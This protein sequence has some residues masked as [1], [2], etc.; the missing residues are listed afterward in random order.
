MKKNTEVDEF[1]R[2]SNAIEGVFDE[3]SLQ[4]AKYAWEYLIKQETLTT[5]VILKTH[6]I[7]MLHQSLRPNEKGYWRCCQV[8][9]GGREAPRWERILLM[10]GGWLLATKYSRDEESIKED[11]VQFEFIHPFVD[12]NGRVGRMLMNW[13]RLQQKLPLLVIKDS[14]KQS[15]YRWFD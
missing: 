4:Q 1:L 8:W 14:E 2:E 12:G 3:D 10:M 5:G 6:K 9:I 13:Q 11:H 15:Y 7:L